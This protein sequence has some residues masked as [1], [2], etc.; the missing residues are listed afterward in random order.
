VRHAGRTSSRAMLTPLQLS[1]VACSRTSAPRSTRSG[2]SAASRTASRFQ[3]SSRRSS[4]SCR[5]STC[6]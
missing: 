1:S 2:S 5:T 3:A 4:R 6:R